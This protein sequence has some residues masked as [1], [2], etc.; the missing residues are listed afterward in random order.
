MRDYLNSFDRFV[1][2]KI[3]LSIIDLIIP[4]LIAFF[5]GFEDEIS[6]ISIR[7]NSIISP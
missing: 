7:R 4:D 3:D 5:L 2:F 1:S 6:S